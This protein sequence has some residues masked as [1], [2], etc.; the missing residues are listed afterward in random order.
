MNL[1]P[2][3]SRCSQN[4]DGAIAGGLMGLLA[5]VYAWLA[6]AHQPHDALVFLFSFTRGDLSQTHLHHPLYPYLLAGSASLAR[7]I[8]ARALEAGLALSVM[9]SA[10]AVGFYYLWLRRALQVVPWLAAGSAL[11]LGL[12]ASVLEN[13]TTVELYGPALCFMVLSLF[14]FSQAEC[15]GRRKDAVLL[16]LFLFLTVATHVGFALWPLA[17]YLTL[18][19]RKRRQSGL[20]AGKWL[21]Q[22]AL[23]CALLITW[24]GLE[25]ALGRLG[26]FGNLDSS[27]D[28]FDRFWLVKS[29][30]HYPLV[31]LIAPA[32]NLAAY[33][34]AILIPMGAGMRVIRDQRSPLFCL[35]LLAS[36]LFF[37]LYAGWVPDLGAFFTPLL[38]LWAG[39]ATWGLES[40]RKKADFRFSLIWMLA[41]LA[42]LAVFFPLGRGAELGQP[43]PQGFF[44][45]YTLL[46]AGAFWG[47][48]AFLWRVLPLTGAHPAQKGWAMGL[49][50]GLLVAQVAFYVP[51]FVA[52]TKP[53]VA[54]IILKDFRALAPR[55]ARL[56]TMLWPPRVW[57]ILEPEDLAVWE[58]SQN[59]EQSIR[60]WLNR[61]LQPDSPPFYLDATTAGNRENLLPEK[62]RQTKIL[63]LKEV[64]GKATSFHLVTFANQPAQP[65][66]KPE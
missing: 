20:A 43:G 60:Q 59:R 47:M 30:W 45:A 24:I 46:A 5:I 18:A 40:F 23:M 13:A 35:T 37:L 33:A 53:T 61:E 4:L 63:E 17:V 34:G 62:Y 3:G 27:G 16:W 11:M 42:Y 28:F 55:N 10:L 48:A 22:G 25:G 29:F 14:F 19:W 54:E 12:T 15:S 39:V 52:R 6:Q 64:K 9:S 7:M 2:S 1:P 38:P 56:V 31:V 21:A 58:K 44:D 57:S 41:S 32:L 51:R 8:G 36:T 26:A 50:I 65:P 49:L 66:K